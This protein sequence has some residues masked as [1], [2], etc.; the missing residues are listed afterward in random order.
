MTRWKTLCRSGRTR[1]RIGSAS[2]LT[3]LRMF[4]GAFSLQ[5]PKE[6]FQRVASTAARGASVGSEI[7]N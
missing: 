2:V 7:V 6:R 1:T 5:P 3:K 4:F